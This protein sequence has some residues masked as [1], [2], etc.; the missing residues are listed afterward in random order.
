MPCPSLEIPM[1]AGRVLCAALLMMCWSGSSGATNTAPR[2]AAGAPA[3]AAGAPPTHVSCPALLNVSAPRLQ[4]E[5]P[6]HL[7]QYAGKVV[8]V[9]NTASLCGYTPQYE[10]LETLFDRYRA[11]GLVVLG[12]PSNQFGGQEPGSNRQIAEFCA[13]TFGV[14]F[15][16]FART[17]VTGSDA[18]PLF[19]E[20]A[21]QSGTAPRWNFHKYLVGRDGRLLG[22]YP[23]AVRPL[24]RQLIRDIERALGNG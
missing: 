17:V 8:L 13:N 15:P 18:H 16:M 7:C 14:R 23:S 24:D 5:Q 6:Q 22:N 19:S 4:D 12:F 2:G 10:G 11:R 20:L 1:T 21:R 9:V 3:V